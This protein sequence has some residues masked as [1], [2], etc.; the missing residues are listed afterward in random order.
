MTDEA[1]V[2]AAV[3]A[4]RRDLA[5]VLAA[6]PSEAWAAPTLCEG[7]RVKEV[8]AHI[9]MPFRYSAPRFIVEMLKSRGSF[10]RMADRCAKQDA[11]SLST[12]DLLL[13][14][15]DNEHHPWKPPGAGFEG[16]LSHDVIHG[17]DMTVALGLDRVVPEDRI[18][19]VIDSLS[20]KSVKFFGVDLG[21]IE[22]RA[23]DIDWS[24]GEG[25]P[26]TGKAQDLL[27][28]LCGRK[29]PAGR[30]HGDNSER[31]VAA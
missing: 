13:S 15:R 30:L 3:A 17:M 11:S 6:L 26:L 28:V 8:V 18:R 1:T 14:L 22:L 27:L 5:D 10:N 7:W 25:S 24:Y 19:I 29:L 23:D 9:T 16:A 31:F 21:G 12:D 2:R 20:P 4:E